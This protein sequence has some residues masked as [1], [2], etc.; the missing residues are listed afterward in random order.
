MKLFFLLLLCSAIKF[1]DRISTLKTL[2]KMKNGWMPRS[3]S[4]NNPVRGIGVPFRSAANNIA[5]TSLPVNS[6][7]ARYVNLSA[8][9]YNVPSNNIPSYNNPASYITRHTIYHHLNLL[10]FLLKFIQIAFQLIRTE[11][12]FTTTYCFP[13]GSSSNSVPVRFVH[14]FLR[15]SLHLIFVSLYW[16]PKGFISH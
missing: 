14:L 3:L 10:L 16:L 9:S 12:F 13:T 7:T 1:K 4:L 6:G 8:S 2:S 5:S 11:I 15:Q